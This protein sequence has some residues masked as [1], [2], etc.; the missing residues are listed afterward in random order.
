MLVVSVDHGAKFVQHERLAVQP[1]PL[2]PVQ[3]AAPHCHARRQRRQRDDRRKNNQRR[4]HQRQIEQ[5]FTETAI[6]R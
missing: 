4:N 1:G 6:H 2:L 3:H 5:S